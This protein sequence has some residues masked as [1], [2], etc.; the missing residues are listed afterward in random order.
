MMRFHALCGKEKAELLP[1]TM[2]QVSWS[3]S[4]AYMRKNLHAGYLM[5]AEHCF[6]SLG[7][8]RSKRF[9]AWPASHS[10]LLPILACTQ[11]LA[12]AFAAS[13]TDRKSVV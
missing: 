11:S 12:G 5:S 3:I 6:T 13:C 10:M 9:H 2:P 4:A 8:V 7:D 1:L